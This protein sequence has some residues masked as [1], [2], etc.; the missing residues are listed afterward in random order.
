M[1]EQAGQR[2]EAGV[3]TDFCR[4][5][6]QRLGVAEG[7]AR[8]TAEV[9][10][11]ADLRGVFSHGVA[12]LRRYVEG[13]RTGLIVAR[14]TETIV[15]ET[16]VSA[17]IDA[18]AGLGPPA[19]C[20]AMALA[21]EK[22]CAVGAGFVTV[23][24]SNHFG[25]AGYYAMQALA[26]DCIGITMTNGAPIAVPTFGRKAALGSNPIAIAAP[27]GTAFPFV[28][29]MATCAVAQGKVEIASQLGKPIPAGWVIDAEG[30][31]ATD[32]ARALAMLKQKTGGG[33]LPLGGAGEGFG[34]HKGY[35][36]AIGVELFSALLSGAAV[37]LETYPKAADGSPLPAD[38]GH[39]FGAWRIDCFRPREEFR[40]AMDA[41]QR[42]LR[43][44]PRLAGEERIYIPG[45]KEFEAEERHRREG[46]PLNRSVAAD[47]RALAG[48]LEIAAVT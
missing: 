40:Q 30:R 26:K 22:A 44:V 5:S 42:K 20:R 9:M 35:G 6:F 3:L 46:V 23:R 28:L 47:L 10:V 33:L 4:R 7:D 16:P 36:L 45:E 11:A 37:S 21:L 31:A 32:S 17:T 2:V 27:A 1:G 19:G 48:E 39:F 41:Y 25:I 14:P 18:G 8:L 12:H 29:D 15:T 38:V 24:K 13:L 34:G 43:E